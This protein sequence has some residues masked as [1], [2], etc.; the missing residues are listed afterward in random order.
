MNN[1]EKIELRNINLIIKKLENLLKLAKKNEKQIPKNIFYNIM[2]IHIITNI[3][4]DINANGN[5]NGNN[6][7]NNEQ[8][9]NKINGIYLLS[10]ILEKGI[11]SAPNVYFLNILN[12]KGLQDLLNLL[13]DFI[14]KEE[15]SYAFFKK[16]IEYLNKNEEL[17]NIIN[18][19]FPYYKIKNN[20]NKKLSILWFRLF[21][22]LY[23]KKIGFKVE[24]LFKN[25]IQSSNEFNKGE[26]SL[27]PVFKFDTQYEDLFL[28]S[29]VTIH[30]FNAKGKKSELEFKFKEKN[31]EKEKITLIFYD[32]I[33]RILEQNIEKPNSDFYKGIYDYFWK[34]NSINSYLEGLINK[35]YDSKKVFNLNIFFDVKQNILGNIF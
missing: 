15:S 27:Y 4:K 23:Q 8:Y 5:D 24:F 33:N 2:K 35:I 34:N 29:G 16:I 17:L 6:L 21:E 14:N 7:I 13:E 22:K 3:L 31:Y 26:D 11:F 32:S 1:C 18:I 25:E 19:I 9:F 28:T 30:K 10:K 12:E 20:N